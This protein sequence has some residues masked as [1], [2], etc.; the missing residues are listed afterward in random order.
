VSLALIG[1]AIGSFFSGYVSDQIGRKKVI[2]FADFM[3]T[4]GAVTMAVA[5][6]IWVLMMGRIFV[7]IGVGVAAQIVPLYLS[8]IAPTEIRGK[9]IAMN[10][11]MITVGQLISVLLVLALIPSWRAML[12]LAAIPSLL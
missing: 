3:F 5:P 11:A 8:E 10:T 4:L 2:L 9:L 6:S 1:A 12:G 7:G